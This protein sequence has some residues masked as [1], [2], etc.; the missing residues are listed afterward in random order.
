MTDFPKDPRIVVAGAVGSTRRIL[1]GLLRNKM[2]V[3]AVFGLAEGVSANVS[4]YSRLDDLAKTH[5][6]PYFDFKNINDSETVG[7]IRKY[8]PDLLFAV[9]F[10]QLVKTELLSIPKFG[11]IGFHPTQLPRGR[12]RAPIAWLIL[13]G[14][15]GAAT[16]FKLEETAD[17]GPILAQV[18]FPV[19]PDDY[20]SDVLHSMDNAIDTAL[21]DWLPQLNQGIWNPH[22]QDDSLATYKPKRSPQDGLIDWTLPAVEIYKLVRAASRPHP[23]AFSTIKGIKLTVWRAS[24]A[25]GFSIRTP[26][27]ILRTEN[28]KGWLVKTGSGQLWLQEVELP[29]GVNPDGLLRPGAR[30]SNSDI[31]KG[32][33][34]KP[35]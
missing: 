14:V 30:F 17:S 25:K 21:D 29:A 28:E 34:G 9:G 5:N 3:A 19:G 7:K 23:G 20:A 16:F 22:T 10:S 27:T 32:L 6:I 2:K 24:P 18:P 26:G 35:S 12:G 11:C 4:G 13:D 15:D 33:K 1:E 8:K 31:N